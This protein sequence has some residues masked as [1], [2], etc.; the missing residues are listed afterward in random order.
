VLGV[1]VDLY[2][3]VGEGVR[4]REVVL[5]VDHLLMPLE[6]GCQG[7]RLVGVLP[8]G[9]IRKHP[10]RQFVTVLICRY[11]VISSSVALPSPRSLS[12]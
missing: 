10:I 9:F 3:S 7:V 4:S 12:G 2:L 6:R 1:V 8:H 11:F 5:S